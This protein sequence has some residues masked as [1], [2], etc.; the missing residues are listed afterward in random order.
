LDTS[1]L[2]LGLLGIDALADEY[3]L[4]NDG[5]GGSTPCPCLREKGWFHIE[6]LRSWDG[7]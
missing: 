5:L 1:C 6:L 7:V 2:A 3:S 4:V